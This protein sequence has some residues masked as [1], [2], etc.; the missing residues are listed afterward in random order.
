MTL[1][2]YTP[3]IE[4]GIENWGIPGPDSYIA[5]A[6][7]DSMYFDLGNEWNATKKR[8]S[9]T[10]EDMFDFFNRPAL[11]D[12]INSGKA[13]KFSH[14]PTKYPDTFLEEEWEYIKKKLFLTD[15]DLIVKGDMFYVG[16]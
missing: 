16:Q 7:G 4:N 8:Y 10:D 11:D 2:K 9:L 5:K 1:G 15:E 13:I 6:G 14:D 3:T 12:A